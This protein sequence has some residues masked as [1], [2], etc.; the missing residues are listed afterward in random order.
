MKIVHWAK[1]YPPE[2]GG[3]ELVTYDEAVASAARG[4]QVEVVAFTRDQARRDVDLGVVIERAKVRAG[5][6]SQ[7]LSLRWLRF[8]IRAG[9]AADVVHIHTPN[10]LA[11]LALPF[12]PRHKQVILQWQ[13]DVVEKGVLGLL[14]RPLELYMAHRAGVLIANSA[15]YAEASPVLR[16]FAA[17]TVAI[18]IGIADPTQAAASD[19]LPAGIESFV[20]GRPIVLAVGR[21]VPYKGFEYLIRAAAEM[22]EEAAVVVVG[23]GRL[24]DRH[25]ALIAQLGASDRVMMAGR[26]AP[27]DLQALFRD[28]ALY[29]MS[30]VKRSEAF[31]IVMLEA[32][33]HGLPVVA[34]NIPGS[35][36]AWVAGEGET[37]PIVAPRDATALAAAID[38]LLAAP[39]ERATLGRRARARFER[40]FLRE[41]MLDSVLSLY[42]RS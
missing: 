17:K 5:I 37:G 16:Q 15:A 14:V 39:G 28:A 1:Y 6:D 38:G 26:V 11:A 22:R 8:A 7:P 36:V 2:W 20:R 4:D 31:G 27:P 18:P 41:R 23:T 30:S 13:T 29:T 33:A 35:G 12:I 10:L 34:T 9:R 42:R 24:E 21:S 32:M 25:R 40:L 19:R 3:T